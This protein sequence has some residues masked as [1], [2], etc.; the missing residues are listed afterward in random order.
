[1]DRRGLEMDAD[2]MAQRRPRTCFFSSNELA[3]LQYADQV[4]MCK[5]RS[6]KEVKLHEVAEHIPVDREVWRPARNDTTEREA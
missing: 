5:A 1:V 4:F 2:T 6:V 3:D